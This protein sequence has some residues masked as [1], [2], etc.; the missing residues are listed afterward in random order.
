MAIQT[1]PSGINFRQILNQFKTNYLLWIVPTVVVTLLSL[2]YALLKKPVW[3]A[4]QAMVVRDEA[5]GKINRQGRFETREAMKTAQETILE[6]ARSQKVVRAA[7]TQAGPAKP[8]A[9][10]SWPTDDDVESLQGAIAVRAPNGAEFGATEVIHV[11]VKGPTRERASV[12]ALAVSDQL[13][14]SMRELRDKKARSI[15]AELDKA[16]KLAEKDLDAATSKLESLESDVGTDLGELRS[17]SNSAGGT[18]NLRQA[19][20][21]LKTELREEEANFE[22]I[23]QQKKHL[24]V[25]KENPDHLIATPNRLL[26]SQPALRRLKEGLVDAQLNTSK[27][28]GSMSKDHPH[29]KAAIVA[30]QEVR[31]DLHSE[32]GLAVRGIE[33]DLAISQTRLTTLRKQESGIKSR[34]D[35]LASLRARYS[36]LVDDVA[37]RTEILKQAQKEMAD[38]RANMTAANSASLITR[39]DGP[40]VGNHPLGPGKTAIVLCG[41]VGG[42]L[43]GLGLVFL[44]EPLEQ[45]RGRRW[46]DL[47]PAKRKSDTTVNGRRE[48]QR[49]GGRRD[50]DPRQPRRATDPE[51]EVAASDEPTRD[52]RSDGDRRANRPATEKA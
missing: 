51:T 2:G 29:V 19:L 23:E 26:D 46:S 24:H 4:T 34:L 36:N 44:K 35:R 1:K 3:Q 17:L 14:Q 6:M 22:L 7:L 39:L 31:Q 16:V 28:M 11:A 15:T 52:R 8:T 13:D 48:A 9:A 12:L 42:L 10:K 30:E 32:L 20:N 49:G 27:L 37:Q 21:Q 40:V 38:A 47:F 41:F 45:L 18:S 5:G 25:A 50:A 43:I 33:A